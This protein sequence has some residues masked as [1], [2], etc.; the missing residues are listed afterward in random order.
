MRL[1]LIVFLRQAIMEVLAASSLSD[2]LPM[3]T[4][5]ATNLMMAIK[6]QLNSALVLSWVLA[7]SWRYTA[8]PYTGS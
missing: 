7:E 4:V 6:E 1:V 2:V 3:D 5:L 8:V